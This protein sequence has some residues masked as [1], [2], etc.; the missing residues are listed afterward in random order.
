MIFPRRFAKFVSAFRTI[1]EVHREIHDI[2]YESNIEDE[3]KLA[4][5]DKIEEAYYM[6]KR[7][8]DKLLEYKYNITPTEWST[9][10]RKVDKNKTREYRA[11]LRKKK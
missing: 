8:N 10:D 7:M 9:P 11:E 3:K 2:I 5:L 4:L 6:A 1:C